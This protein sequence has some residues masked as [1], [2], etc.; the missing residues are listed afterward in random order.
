MDWKHY[1]EVTKKIYET[2]GRESGVKIIGY[3]NQCIVRG[4]SGVV[5]QIDVL[6]AHSDG[7][8]EYKTAI[9]CKYWKDKVN[10]D[11]VMKVSEIIQDNLI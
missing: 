2:L 6:T 10:K 4:K 1:E 8:H 11:I 3:G 5:H 7:I 9:E